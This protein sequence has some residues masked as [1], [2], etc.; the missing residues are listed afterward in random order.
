MS[1]ATYTSKSAYVEGTALMYGFFI[2]VIIAAIVAFFVWA[3]PALARRDARDARR[4]DQ[5][6]TAIHQN[7][8]SGVAMNDI[9][10][11]SGYIGYYFAYQVG[12]CNMLINI[13][14]HSGNYGTYIQLKGVE[15][16]NVY[17]T[18]RRLKKL[19]QTQPCFI[20]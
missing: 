3:V 4:W 19:P 15:D 7:G 1:S 13:G 8:F 17:V 18:L 5:R 6:L 11:S 20:K 10:G 2:A 14:K 16:A 9:K 12:S